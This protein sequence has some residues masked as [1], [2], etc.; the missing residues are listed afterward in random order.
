MD[1]AAI[2]YEGANTANPPITCPTPNDGIR[3]MMAGDTGDGAP[4]H[5]VLYPGN[6]YTILTTQY[7]YSAGFPGSQTVLY[8]YTGTFIGAI[9]QPTTGIVTTQRITTARVTT[10][11]ATSAGASSQDL[12]SNGITSN[13]VTTGKLTSEA[14]STMG[15]SST[16]RYEEVT[17]EILSITSGQLS[18]ITSGNTPT[19]GE[20]DMSIAVSQLF[21]ISCILLCI[22]L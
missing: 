1:T 11:V 13:G 15:I 12:T 10:Q 4:L 9:P 3:F 8:L 17:S 2:L 22:I 21:S 14:V 7:G 18:E 19:T 20:D 16:T 6:S 5:G